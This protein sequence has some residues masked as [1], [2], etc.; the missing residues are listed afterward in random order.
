M[1]LLPHLAGVPPDLAVA[2]DATYREV[3][4]HYLKEEWDDAQV[5]AGRFCEAVLRYLEWRMT[6]SYTP[7]DGKS[8]PNRKKVVNDARQETALPPTL[9][10]QVPQAVELIMDFRNNRNAAHLGDIDANRMDA[11]TVVQNVTWLVGEIL[12][13]ESKSS[14]AEV[15]AL[16]DQIAERH[17]PLI[18]KVGD[19]P[20][21]LD[22]D[23]RSEE[24]VLLFLYQNPGAVPIARLQ[25]WAEYAHS[26]RWREKVIMPLHHRRLVHL[27]ADGQVHL[28]PP[29]EAAAQRI[30][31]V[32]GHV[33]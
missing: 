5:D 26:T 29:G 3:L 33:T 11:N 2:I 27:D 22:P 7:I 30:L 31:L 28:L 14:P 8:K 16:L 23:L 25:K 4:D 6:G 18:H 13:L 24:K 1:S 20:V 21:I 19:T 15:Q 12:R 32:A 10:A 9:R 17:V